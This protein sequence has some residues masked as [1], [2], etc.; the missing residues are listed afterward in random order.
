MTET[1]LLKF[2]GEII[3]DPQHLR[4]AAQEIAWL[5]D[6]ETRITVVHGGGPQ[7]TAFSKRLGIAP[8]VVAGRRITDAATLDVMKMVVA[9]KLNTDLVAA[10]QGAQV[11]AL[12]VSGVSAGIVLAKKRPPRRVAGGGDLP[13]DFGLVGDVVA[14]NTSLLNLLMN[15]RIVPV[16]ASLGADQRGMVYNINA[17]IIATRMA[18]ALGVDTLFLFSGVGGVLAD[19]RDPATRYHE[20]T[21][22]E[23]RTIMSEGAVSGGMLPKLEE[24]ITA[25]EAGVERVHILGFETEQA[26]QQ[27]ICTPREIGT[28]LRK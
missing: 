1:V 20:L 11:S 27:A 16:V 2:G 3:G 26:L 5:Y 12:G 22:A 7:A 4:R 19:P 21:V 10:L 24:A 18:V 28:I 25:L 9:G 13:I 15:N 17:D 6:R 23:A 8:Q 14:N